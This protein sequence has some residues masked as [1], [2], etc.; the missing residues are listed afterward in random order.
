VGIKD[1]DF[2]EILSNLLETVVTDFNKQY[3]DGIDLKKKIPTLKF[4]SGMI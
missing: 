3:E 4:V 2:D 1:D